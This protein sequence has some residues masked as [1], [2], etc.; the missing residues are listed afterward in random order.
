[1]AGFFI[2]ASDVKDAE[3]YGAYVK[4]APDVMAGFT[5]VM[6]ARGGTRVNLEGPPAPDRIVIVEFDS[7]EKGLQC[8]N[9]EKYKEISAPAANAADVVICA[10]DGGPLEDIK[11]GDKP[12]YF[13]AKLIVEDK[14]KYSTYAAKA[15]DLL[16]SWNASVIAAGPTTPV[17]GTQNYQSLALLR[18]PELKTAVDFYNSD[19]YQALI[20]L[21][22]GAAQTQFFAVEGL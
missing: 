20:P 21:R 10:L 15:S 16:P 2:T 4:Q 14:E 7:L 11:V 6:R 18:F 8:Y 19:E 9:S 3:T 1:M 5:G 12:G 17:K 22:E 13:V